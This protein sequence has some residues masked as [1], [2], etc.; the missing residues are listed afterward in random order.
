MLGQVIS[1]EYSAMRL[2]A[3]P[4]HCNAEFGQSLAKTGTFSFSMAHMDWKH[5][6]NKL[7]RCVVV[8]ACMRACVMLAYVYVSTNG[9]ML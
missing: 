2:A 3:S 9:Q 6:A 5:K 8:C 4:L 1:V 7:L